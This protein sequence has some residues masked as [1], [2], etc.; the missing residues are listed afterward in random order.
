M[1]PNKQICILDSFN[2]RSNDWVA[3]AAGARGAAVLAMCEWKD[4]PEALIDLMARHDG[5]VSG[6]FHG[7]TLA[8]LAGTPVIALPGNTHKTGAMMRDFGL[9]G[10][11]CNSWENLETALKEGRFGGMDPAARAPSL[12]PASRSP[13]CTHFPDEPLCAAAQ[14]RTY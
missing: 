1:K 3:K 8:W 10:S 13:K 9:E 4:S 6:R 11:Y 14:H 5:V 2:K 12:F 7:V